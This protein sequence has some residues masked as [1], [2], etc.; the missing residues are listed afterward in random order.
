MLPAQGPEQLNPEPATAADTSLSPTHKSTGVNVSQ[1]KQQAERYVETLTGSKDTV[2]TWQTFDDCQADGHKKRGWLSKII[3]GTLEECWSEL[4]AANKSG[5]GVYAMVNTG[6]GKGRAAGNVKA[7]RALFVDDDRG[8]VAVDALSLTPSMVVQSAHGPHCYWRLE[9]GVKLSSFTPGQQALIGKLNTDKSI[10]DL[11]RVMRVPGFLHLKDPTKPFQVSLRYDHPHLVYGFEQV[12]GAFGVHSATNHPETPD[13]SIARNLPE[14][15]IK[16]VSSVPP[17]VQGEAGDLTTYRIAAHLVRDLSIPNDQALALMLEWN[18]ANSPPWTERELKLKI[19]N[20]RKYGKTEPP[21]LDIIRARDVKRD[22]VKW[23]WPSRLAYGKVSCLQ[24]NGG[25]GKT[26]LATA[27]AARLSTGRSLTRGDKTEHEPQNVLFLSAEDGL[28]D[29]MLPRYLLAGGDIDRAFYE[30]QDDLTATR[31]SLPSNAPLLEQFIGDNKISFVILDPIASYLDEGIKSSSDQD[32]RRALQALAGV[33]QRTQCI[34]LFLQHLNKNRD[35]ESAHRGN[36]SVA[37]VNCPR[38]VL[39]AAEDPDA[40]GNYVLSR[41]KGNHGPPPPSISYSIVQ[42]PGSDVAQIVWGDESEHDSDSL[43]RARPGPAPVKTQAAETFLIEALSSGFKTKDLILAQAQELGISRTVMYEAKKVL[44][45]HS[46]NSSG[47]VMWGL[48]DSPLPNSG[49]SGFSTSLNN[50]NNIYNRRE[51]GTIPG[52]EGD[53][54]PVTSPRSVPRQSQDHS[55]LVKSSN[56]GMISGSPESQVVTQ[57]VL[58]AAS[59]L[60]GSIEHHV[61]KDPS[62]TDSG[63]QDE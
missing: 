57:G 9:D 29:V 47:G 32:V 13:T 51:Q 8:R 36:G 49:Y 23:A 34:T 4:V 22:R 54:G 38:F 58:D 14:R 6:D 44:R 15:G 7:V 42:P 25:V 24:G 31:L 21:K 20:A 26:T 62:N 33:T 35:A 2:M 28:G 43:L 48:S 45:L 53:S 5:A 3:H 17:A 61:I 1:D 30:S 19:E 63:G 12:L 27:L 50:N 52:P 10:H 59:V 60:G 46:T 55:G 11:P 39:L 16:Y 37:F 41:T 56:A 18:K 40:K